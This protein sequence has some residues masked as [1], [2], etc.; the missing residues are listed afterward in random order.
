M[1]EQQKQHRVL[2]VD[3]EAHVTVVLARSLSKLG[4]NYVIETANSGEEALEKARATHY[5][6]VITDYQM[7]EMNGLD[8]IIALRNVTP[9]TRLV[10]MTAYGN[11][12][13]RGA[14]NSVEVSGYLDKPFTLE[15]IRE[16]VQ[17]AV[18]RSGAEE[19]PF[20]KGERDI[21]DQVHQELAALQANTGAR[22]VMLIS[23]NGYPIEAVGAVEALDLASIGV[24]V[25]ANF[26][27]AVELSKLLGND[28]IF[29]SSYHEGPDYNIYAYDI[30]KEV[31]LA[32][33]FGME[34]RTGAVWFYTKQA[35]TTL[36]PHLEQEGNGST[37]GLAKDKALYTDLSALDREL[38]YL[39][40]SGEEQP[41]DK[42]RLL[43]VEEAV[44]AGL[45]PAD[46][47]GNKTE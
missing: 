2:I 46:L 31:L 24:L 18:S 38:D 12:E 42:R 17:R 6:L 28:S 41:G 36:Q 29:K 33:I 16:V 13:L 7:P 25:A 1:V 39:F 37:L 14:V 20:R 45:I 35:A 4:P 30:N 26:A 40:G 19:D 27:A 43:D 34:S 44:A 5:D 47:L 3:D 15:Q 23:N 22:C 10:L 9:E 32:V 8:L 11:D 21:D